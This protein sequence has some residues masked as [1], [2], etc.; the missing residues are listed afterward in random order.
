VVIGASEGSLVVQQAEAET[1]D[2]PRVPTDTTFILIAD[3]NFGL[4]QGLHGVY[5]PIRD[6]HTGGTAGD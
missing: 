2:D 6:L 1:N 5:I 4:V 3:P